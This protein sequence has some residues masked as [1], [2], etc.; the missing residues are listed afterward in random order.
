LT[1]GKVAGYVAAGAAATIVGIA[2]FLWVG[3]RQR[4]KS[5]ATAK[6]PVNV[7]TATF[8]AYETVPMNSSS[9]GSFSTANYPAGRQSQ[10]HHT[11]DEYSDIYMQ[12]FTS[13]SGM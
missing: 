11:A 10:L 4:T 8:S 6:Q 7:A 3:R 9:R 13:S 1:I 12:D 2:L 5:S